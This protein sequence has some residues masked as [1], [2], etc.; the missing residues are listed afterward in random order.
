MNMPLRSAGVLFLLKSICVVVFKASQNPFLAVYLGGL[1]VY[2]VEGA[3]I[4]QAPS[5]VFVVVGEEDGIQVT[6]IG[7]EH[8]AAEIRPG[9]NEDF[10]AFILN[11]GRRTESLVALIRAF[12]HRALACYDRH[13]L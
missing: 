1:A 3:D 6:D 13:A 10:K 7:P 2:V 5:V 4:V 9:V 8:L 12:A 11:I